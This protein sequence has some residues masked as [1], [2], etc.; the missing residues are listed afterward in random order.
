MDT[1]ILSIL[2]IMEWLDHNFIF[3]IKELFSDL[4]IRNTKLNREFCE[5]VFYYNKIAY[6]F[7]D[8]DIW[9]SRPKID[10]FQLLSLRLN[11]KRKF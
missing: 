11:T 7:A 2:G 8:V 3:T 9:K 4:G 5:K 6:K 10:A 1:I